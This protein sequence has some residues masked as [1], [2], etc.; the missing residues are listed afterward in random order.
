MKCK[1]MNHRS[2]LVSFIIGMFLWMAFWTVI[3]HAEDEGS[4][5]D[6]LKKAVSHG[7]IDHLSA[8]Y[9][10]GYDIDCANA[11]TPQKTPLMDAVAKRN[12]KVVRYLVEE[13]RADT[14]AQDKWGNTALMRAV[15]EKNI[16]IITIL[17]EGSA[18]PD[19]VNNKGIGALQIAISNELSEVQT[20]LIKYGAG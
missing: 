11:S 12:V 19:I 1:R 10:A 5:C 8:C 3:A 13:L 14:D 16:E 15:S 9:Y 6:E 17:L 7:D 18:D 4:Q 20:L 2:T